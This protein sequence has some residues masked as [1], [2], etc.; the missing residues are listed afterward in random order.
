MGL[1]MPQTIIIAEIGVNHNGCLNMAKALVE[2]AACSGADMVKFQ[3]F[4]SDHLATPMAP[5]A[6]Y[7]KN[8]TIDGTQLDM[9]KQL[10][11]TPKKHEQL[12]EHCD[13]HRVKF[14]SAPFDLDSINLLATL[15]LDTLKIPSGEITNAP[16]L[17]TIGALN[18]NIIMSTGMSTLGEVAAAV[19]ELIRAGTPEYKITLLHCTTEYPAPF[20]E[21][22][23]KAME[24][25]RK[26]F[27]TIA[28][29]GYSDHTTGITVPIAAAALGA[30]IIEKHFTLDKTMSGPDHKAS[31]EP[32]EFKAMCQGIR[33]VELCL[34]TGDKVP[35]ASELPNKEVARKS[36]VAAHDIACG[37][38]FTEKNITAKRPGTG[39]SPMDWDDIIGAKSNR[40]YKAGELI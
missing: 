13:A 35:T 33:Q 12:I 19:S 5:K 27:P 25:M 20:E 23:L 15:Q 29:V 11:L 28:G 17:R 10:E 31:L 16:Y 40:A 9:L 22:N 3:T 21:V 1:I 37:E 32:H 18:K 6:A 8:N 34:G 24:T 36:I 38:I 2:A 30:T 4:V 14:L 26:A 7:Q 39:L